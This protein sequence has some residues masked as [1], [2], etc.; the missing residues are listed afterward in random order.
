L[1][2]KKIDRGFAGMAVLP[3]GSMIVT[4]KFSGEVVLGSG[5]NE[6]RLTSVGDNSLFLAKLD[7]NMNPL[8]AKRIET[9]KGTARGVKVFQDGSIVLTGT[10]RDQITF[11]P[12][13]A[14]KIQFTSVKYSDTYIAK[15]TSDGNLIW[16]KHIG[17]NSSYSSL[18]IAA[19]SGGDLMVVGKFK[20]IVN[21]GENTLAEIKLKSV[22]KG[23]IFVAKLDSEGSLVWAKRFNE[24]IVSDSYL[25]I[26]SLNDGGFLLTGM[27]KYPVTFAEGKP[28][29]TQISAFGSNSDI[30]I[31]KY[32]SDGTFLWVKREG[33]MEVDIV[34]NILTLP[35]GSFFIEGYFHEVTTIGSGE[36]N[37]IIFTETGSA[38]RF[39]A[40]FNPDGA[41]IWAKRIGDS[42]RIASFADGSVVITGGFKNSI[43]FG[44]GEINQTT[45]SS[46]GMSDIYITKFAANGDL[47][48]VKQSKGESMTSS[49][50]ITVL[51]D[52][53]IT[54]FGSFYKKT[55]FG[56]NEANETSLSTASDYQQEFFILKM[57]P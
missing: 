15:F 51:Q 52:S 37:E 3:D 8:W 55:I 39:L 48:W 30:F 16:A 56:P 49:S 14:D 20:N 32:G 25:Y 33:G 6:I 9:E 45:L 1:W 53:S 4:D 38:G 10:F 34:Q 47:K 23:D 41:L 21:F 50:N 11:K 24:S 35:N 17:G 5:D 19:L 28:N 57:Q 40:K 44:D 26:D 54:I 31:A 43:V 36:P 7:E 22:G 29:E 42:N 2:A 46:T 27:F 18:K 12:D 13:S